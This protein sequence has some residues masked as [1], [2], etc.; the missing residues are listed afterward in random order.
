M[1]PEC[2]EPVPGDGEQ[3]LRVLAAGVNYADTHQIEDSYLA[4]QTLPMIPGGEVVVERARRPPA[5]RPASAPAAT[6]SGS[7]STRAGCSRCRTASAT[8]RR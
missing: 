6:P 1:V 8:R 4:Q 7:R 3:V 5:A 2:P